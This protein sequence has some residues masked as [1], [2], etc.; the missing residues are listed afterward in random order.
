MHLTIVQ[1]SYQKIKY[2]SSKTLN[3]CLFGNL[4]LVSNYQL[5]SGN[6]PLFSMLNLVFDFTTRKTEKERS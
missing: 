3:H 4:I 2:K 5:F 1:K 6:V